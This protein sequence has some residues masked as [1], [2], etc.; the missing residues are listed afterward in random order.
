M[1]DEVY[2]RY[3]AAVEAGRAGAKTPG[4][5]CVKRY[6]EADA[7][8]G[9][10]FELVLERELPAGW[11]AQMPVWKPGDKLATRAASGKV[12]D[13]IAPAHPDPRSAARPT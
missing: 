9:Q 3:R 13:A 8:A 7:A 1:P 12:L 5:T 2:G 4:S 10:A 11:D 6:G